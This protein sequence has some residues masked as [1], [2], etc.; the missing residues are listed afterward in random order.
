MFCTKC[1][2]QISD[3]SKFCIKCGTPVNNAKAPT[4]VQAVPTQATPVATPPVQVKKK[5]AGKTVLIIVV[6]LLLL[7]IIGATGFIGYRVWTDKQEEA[8]VNELLEEAE[9][10]L[11]DDDL[12]GAISCYLDAL[13]IRS[14]DPDIYKELAEIYVQSGEIKKAIRTLEE[15]YEITEDKKLK[16][17]LDSYTEEDEKQEQL[18]SEAAEEAAET[19]PAAPAP[20]EVYI[21]EPQYVDMAIRQVDSSNFPKVIFYASITDDYEKVVENLDKSDFILEEMDSAGYVSYYVIDDVYQLANEDNASVSLVLDASG[22]MDSNDKMQQAKN[23]AIGFVDKVSLETGDQVGIISFDDY[24]YQEQDFTSDK[25][26]LTTAIE[27]INHGGETALYDAIYAGLNQT[28]YESG[29]K[30]VIA[31]TGGADNASNYSFDDI[32]EMAQNTGIPVYIIGIGEGYDTNDLQELAYQCSGQYYSADV[33]NLES[34]LEEIYL[35]IYEAQKNYYVFSFTNSNDKNPQKS[36]DLML[37]T[38]DT[39]EVTGVCDM[40]FYV[41][42][43]DIAGAFSSDYMDLDYII[44]DSATRSLTDADLADLSLAELRIARNEIFARHGRQFRDALLNQWFYSKDWYL[45]L[46]VKYAPDSF[47]AISPSPLSKIEIENTEFIKAY[48]DNIINNQDIY[49]NAANV[50]LTEY[51]LALSKDILK[52]ALAQIQSYSQTDI[53]TENIVL[54]QKAI[55]KEDVQY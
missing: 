50:K 28:F 2:N 20:E 42:I 15:G 46:A 47:D 7:A 11:D 49:P 38:S 25:N 17:L 48:E 44:A 39:S 37:I 31:F 21:G 19:D 40:R 5:G 55:D 29:A 30:C 52:V 22:S 14:D 51:D 45:D 6:V 3:D 36:R 24:V 8:A 10:C 4:P 32:V 16:K 41:P 35:G 27:G 43:P 23:A 12:E 18:E 9:E 54:V 1:G 13:E 33:S 26:L 34:I 53:L